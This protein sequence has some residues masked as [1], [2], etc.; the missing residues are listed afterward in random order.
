MIF[1]VSQKWK[2]P[3]APAYQAEALS[4]NVTWFEY[5]RDHLGYRLELNR[6]SFPTSVD[7]YLSTRHQA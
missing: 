3:L 7:R 5:I 4:R 6:A 2:L 1:C